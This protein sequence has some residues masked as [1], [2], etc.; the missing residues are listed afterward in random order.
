M[1]SRWLIVGIALLF[2]LTI[3][4]S[5]LATNHEQKGQE[6]ARPEQGQEEVRPEQGQE[7]AKLGTGR[8]PIRQEKPGGSSCPCEC[9]VDNQAKKCWW[10]VPAGCSS[11]VQGGTCGPYP[12]C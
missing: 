5:S 1:K 4:G 9:R 11:C 7:K 6:E 12:T 8:P 2:T 10:A 3:Q